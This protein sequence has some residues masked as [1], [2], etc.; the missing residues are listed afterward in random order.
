A[1]DIRVTASGGVTGGATVVDAENG[2]VKVPVNGG[3]TS[4]FVIIEG[5]RVSIANTGVTSVTARLSWARGLNI[6]REGPTGSLSFKSSALVVDKVSAGLSVDPI[7]DNF[8]IYA[9]RVVK[10]TG[11]VLIHEGFATAFTDATD[12]GQDTP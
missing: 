6:F 10:D 8:S 12:F 5:I 4:G 9:N 11:V 7:S 1:A 3:A 2:L